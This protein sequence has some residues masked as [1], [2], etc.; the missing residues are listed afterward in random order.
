MGGGRGRRLGAALA[1]ATALVAVTGATGAA[2]QPERDATPRASRPAPN[3]PDA[4]RTNGGRDV[5]AGERHNRLA[6][7]TGQRPQTME[8]V[9]SSTGYLLFTGCSNRCR[10]ALFVTF[11]GGQSWVERPLPV[12]VA[13]RLQL[14][15]VDANTVVLTAEPGTWFVSR[16]TGRTFQESQA[17]PKELFQA[18]GGHVQIRCPSGDRCP[19]QVVRDGQ[20]VPAQPALPGE[21]RFATLGGDGRIW[22]VSVKDKEANTAVSADG[23][24]TWRRFGPALPLAETG[25]VQLTAAPDSGEV[26]LVAGAGSGPIAIY[27]ADAD[28]WRTVMVSLNLGP[29]RVAAAAVGGGALA[30]GSGE[31]GFV[32]SDGRW[33]PSDPPRR[34][35]F[36]YALADGTVVA[37]SG[38]DDVW[39]GTGTGPE[40]H[41]EHVTV[42][43]VPA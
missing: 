19:V 8:F 22:V 35:A 9:D 28:R 41:W 1:A 37:G 3:R 13:D 4:G 38:P 14:D 23:G 12:Q 32:L 30:T 10:G 17:P 15:V 2:C 43:G 21:L 40:R 7:L 27:Y 29:G 26:W 31:F 11:D 16:D 18:G 5:A 42:E 24:R 36:L 20:A 34:V 25:A 6:V 33:W 39:L